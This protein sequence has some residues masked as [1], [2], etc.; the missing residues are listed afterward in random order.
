MSREQVEFLLA[1]MEERTVSRVDKPLQQSILVVLQLA[2][3]KA[4][5]KAADA[6]LRQREALFRQAGISKA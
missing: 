2:L 6:T 3:R 5:D 1:V 4:D